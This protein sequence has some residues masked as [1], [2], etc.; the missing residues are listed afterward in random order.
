VLV[1]ATLAQ[2]ESTWPQFRGPGGQGH[3]TATDLPLKWDESTNI[4]WKSPIEGEGWSSPVVADG[5]IWLTSATEVEATDEQREAKTKDANNNQPLEVAQQVTFWANE[6]DLATGEPL[7]RIKLRTV[8]SPQAIHALNSF[9][10]PTPVLDDGRLYCHFGDFGTVCLDTSSGEVVWEKRFE[11]EH[12]V[13]PGSSPVLVDGLL[14]LT[15]DGMDTQYIVALDAAD[16]EVAWRKERPPLRATNG[17]FRKSYCTPLL[18]EVD[19]AEQLVIPGAQWFIAYDPATGDEIWRIDHGRGFSIVPRPVFDGTHVFLC[20]GFATQAMW[21]IRPDGQ[22]DVTDS[23]VSWKQSKQIPTMPSP[24]IVGDHIYTVSD[25]G[26]AQCFERTTGEPVW[27][28][29]IGGKFSA[30]PLAADGRIFL[31]NHDGLTTVL[32]PG[33]SYQV[34]A[35]N[36]LDGQL[37]ASPVV[38]DNDLLLRTGTHLYR[39]G[40]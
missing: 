29:R 12:G 36:Q 13:G 15:C 2:A 19:G 4:V 24:V 26:V 3:S 5:K 14:V 37:M 7:R 38:V 10:S 31:S 35:E 17:D 1:V 11:L 16:G 23:H 27:K 9:A 28:E 21:A 39:I 40:E 8:D 22:G 33:D 6:F 34:L 30:S 32:Q 18:I 25:G 20:T